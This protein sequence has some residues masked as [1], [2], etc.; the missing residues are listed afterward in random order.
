MGE[1]TNDHTADLPTGW[2]PGAGHEAD[3]LETGLPHE[4]ADEPRAHLRRV[5]GK[6]ERRHCRRGRCS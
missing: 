1:D 5:A 2:E 6:T 4:R 3:D